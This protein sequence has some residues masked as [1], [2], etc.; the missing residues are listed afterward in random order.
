MLDLPLEYALIDFKGTQSFQARL[1]PSCWIWRSA[2]LCALWTSS[3][4]RKM[5]TAARAPS[6]S[7]I[8]IQKRTRCLPLGEHVS[9]L[10]TTDDLQIAA[11]KLPNN[12]RRCSS[13]GKT[14]GLPI[15]AK[16]S[17]MPA[18]KWWSARRLLPKWWSSSCRKCPQNNV[19]KITF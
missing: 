2:R 13:Y 17:R 6:N 14:C 18:A 15:S 12:R 4:S 10:F 19:I 16:P 5:K 7:T 3:S 9:S 1:S 11:S 8:S